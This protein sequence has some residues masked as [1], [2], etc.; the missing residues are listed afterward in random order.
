[1]NSK[2]RRL[3][4]VGRAPKDRDG[5]RD[6]AP[7]I[8]VHDIDE[9]H[10]L[11]R[12]LPLPKTVFNI[13]GMAACA[14]TRRLYVAHYGRFK[15]HS[16]DTGE[17]AP[18]G[19][20]LL[21][22]DLVTGSPLWERS[23]LPS[24]DR[25]AL[26]PDGRKIYF[27]AGEERVEPFWAV[28]DAHT[29]NPLRQITVH[30]KPHN[31]IVSLDGRRAFLQAFGME[32]QPLRDP[33]TKLPAPDRDPSDRLDHRNGFL[34]DQERTIAVV[35]TATDR[36][37]RR[38]GPFQERVR[39]FTINGRGT[40]VF[41]TMNDFLGF[42]V[43]DAE[44]GRVLHT[45]SVPTD[46]YPQPDPERNTIFTHGIGMTADETQIWV[47]DQKNIGLHHW[48]VRGLPGRAPVWKGFVKTRTGK[49]DI[50]GQPGWIMST[51][52][53]R[54]FYPETCE[55]IDTRTQKVVGQLVGA[56]G[57]PTHSRFAL[58]VDMRGDTPVRC[59]DQFA[60]GRVT[61]RKG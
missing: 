26:T 12:V 53:G 51:I 56:N 37:I 20:R 45:A 35:D 27:P 18:G 41:A 48:D 7:S 47:V 49:P 46:R 2:E 25:F 57:K 10:K 16:E 50:F 21:C 15:G 14:G 9:G 1:M 30:E 33:K 40:L 42:Q 34:T 36:I 54:Y 44:T 24:A 5:F 39:P 23:Y 60:V 3:L 32:E 43:G 22:V 52:D 28:L 8:E 61:G 59:G 13:R 6:L 4:Y 11:V 17:S 38:V 55:I 58:E 29:G 19:G 31:T